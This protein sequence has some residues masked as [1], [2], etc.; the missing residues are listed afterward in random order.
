MWPSQPLQTHTHAQKQ[1]NGK[2]CKTLLPLFHCRPQWIHCIP[3][4]SCLWFYAVRLLG[5]ATPSDDLNMV[6]TAFKQ[7]Q[8]ANNYLENIPPNCTP[9]TCRRRMR[10]HRVAACLDFS[11]W[12]PWRKVIFE[13]QQQKK[14]RRYFCQGPLSP[15]PWT[16]RATFMLR[17]H[18]LEAN[19]GDFCNCFKHG[20]GGGVYALDFL[21]EF[22]VCSFSLV[23]F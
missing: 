16:H 17:Q 13:Q 5:W 18:P 2:T 21:V 7:P 1:P 22:I 3:R 6:E 14:K 9:P 19:R 23:C 4:Q 8:N 10:Q 20:W 11:V 15:L 12:P